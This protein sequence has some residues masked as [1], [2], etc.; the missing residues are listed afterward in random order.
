MTTKTM[1]LDPLMR[2]VEVAEALGVSA[3]FVLEQSDPARETRLLERVRLG[4][5]TIRFRRSDVEALIS[6]GG[7]A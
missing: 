6:N 1:K 3:R 2:T 4:A 5:K 7:L